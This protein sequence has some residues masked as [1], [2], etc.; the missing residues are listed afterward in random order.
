[1]VDQ[2]NYPI[3]PEYATG[4]AQFRTG[5]IHSYAVKQ[6]DI[7][8][9]KQD[10]PALNLYATGVAGG[11]NRTVFGQKTPAFRD[12]RV[13]QAMSMSWD[14]DLWIA[15][16]SNVDKFQAAGLQIETRWN[17]AL[18][19]TDD[20][21]DWWLDPKGKEFGENAKYLKM[22][23]AEAKKL[24]AAAGYANGLDIVNVIATGAGYDAN[25]NANDILNGFAKEVG[26]RFTNVVKDYAN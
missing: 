17:T 20:V 3:V 12:G 19:A 4:L 9:T 1:Y 26:F 11:G 25:W 21:Y 24:M 13:R 7:L 8:L 14:R 15:V 22:D 18:P 23:I 16:Q 2:V 10:L 6:E 5:S